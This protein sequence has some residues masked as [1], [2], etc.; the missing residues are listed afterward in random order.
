[1][2]DTLL[3]GILPTLDSVQR[4]AQ[5]LADVFPPTPLRHSPA[6]TSLVGSP[7][8]LKLECEQ[9]TGSFKVRG[10]YTVLHRMSA[11]ERARGVVAS[12]AG[13][14]GLGV[15]WASHHFRGAGNALR[16]EACAAV[17]EGRHRC[18]WHRR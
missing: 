3:P 1:M 7:V 17:E 6:L 10:A 12:S 13:N 15:A 8:W 14:H 16:T 5:A 11:E 9:E 2:T 18:A 4:A